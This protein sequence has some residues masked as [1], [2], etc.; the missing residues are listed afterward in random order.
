VKRFAKRS[1]ARAIRQLVKRALALPHA[2]GI[3][4]IWKV[5]ALTV[6][7]NAA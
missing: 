4:S 2:D 7:F 3:P 5:M 6:T 1:R